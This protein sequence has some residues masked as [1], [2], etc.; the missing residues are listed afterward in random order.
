MNLF[1]DMEKLCKC[2]E[3]DEQLLSEIRSRDFWER[4]FANNTRDLAKA[5]IAQ[6]ELIATV[7]TDLQELLGLVMDACEREKQLLCI[8]EKLRQ[9]GDK[10][11]AKLATAIG[12]TLQAVSKDHETILRLVSASEESQKAHAAAEAVKRGLKAFCQPL[13]KVESHEFRQALDK[14]LNE[15]VLQKGIRLRPADKE[16]IV[17]CVR[18]LQLPPIEQDQVG[19]GEKVPADIFVEGVLEKRFPESERYTSLRNELVA[20]INQLVSHKEEVDPSGKS[21]EKL[22]KARKKLLENQF[23]I[24]L[25]GEFQG[26]KSTTFNALCGGREIAPRGFGLKTSAAVLT[27]QNIS[28]DETCNGLSEWAE[29][30]WLSEAELRQ[31]IARSVGRAPT[32]RLD[33]LK[34]LL[35]SKWRKLERLGTNDGTKDLLQ[36]SLL[37]LHVLESG[38]YGKWKN[39][40]IVPIDEFQRYV[41]FPKDWK[42]RWAS[43]LEADF[44]VEESLFTCLD[45]VLVHIHSDYLERLGC[46]ITDCPGLFVGRWDTLKAFEVMTRSNAV[47]YLMDGNKELDEAQEG[48]LEKIR[49]SGSHPKCF[50][51]LNV[52]DEQSSKEILEVDKTKLKEAGF[53][54]ENR[55]YKFNAQVAFRGAQ[56]AWAKTGKFSKRD[57]ECLANDM[58]RDNRQITREA[59][60]NEL[61]SGGTSKRVSAIRN[62]LDRTLI[63]ANC[64]DASFHAMDDNKYA[65]EIERIAGMQYVV[66]QLA[67]HITT[68]KALSILLGDAGSGAELCKRVLEELKNNKLLEE[69]LATKRHEEAKKQWEEGNVRWSKF[70]DEAN[71][72]FRYLDEDTALDEAFFHDFY[73]C[74]RKDIRDTV[75]REAE[76]IVIDEDKKLYIL[77]SSFKKEV[78]IDISDKFFEC[79]TTKFNQYANG[80]EKRPLYKER[81]ENRI[82]ESWQRLREKWEEIQKEIPQFQGLTLDENIKT[83]SHSSLT[84]SISSSIENLLDDVIKPKTLFGFLLGWFKGKTSQEIHELFEEHDPI[85]KVL[86]SVEDSKQESQKFKDEFAQVRTSNKTKING[87]L[88]EIKAKFDERVENEKKAMERSQTERNAKAEESHQVRSKIIEPLIT[89]LNDFE[90]RVWAIYGV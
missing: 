40:V 28:N 66:K 3:S 53:N 48:V 52:R 13:N 72:E 89:R 22:L 31:R 74:H 78:I 76:K 6:N 82:S 88:Q 16:S 42:T 47:W 17:E 30:T 50:F 20:I 67:R 75:T 27:A 1:H 44:S 34:H 51:T 64:D 4:L 79:F 68:H 14:L 87:A 45:S 46:Q 54:L 2:A 49:E 69:K 25:F 63:K 58:A 7:Q 71:R 43:G 70:A 61:Q 56:M 81:I 83:V 36:I 65:E 12:K 11:V 60:F 26:G 38:Q 84:K 59:A 90:S 62:I 35:K 24:S 77:P 5:G 32:T 8:V 86:D 80:I 29:I 37:Q 73:A 10:E 18:T 85:D 19:G 41:Q 55:I 9:S 33:R 57:N 15:C 39:K 23:E 21:L